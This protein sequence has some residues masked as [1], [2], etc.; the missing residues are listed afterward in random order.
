MA[1]SAN[2]LVELE[3]RIF[4]VRG[5][6]VM[7][8]AD[9]AQLYG[10]ETKALL[11]AMRRNRDRLPQDFVFH[12]T[13]QEVEV[14]RSQIVSSKPADG[15]GGRRYTC[16]AFTEQGVAMLSSVLRSTTAVQVN[17]AIMRAFVRLRRASLISA[18][19]MKLIEDLSERVNSHD[20]AIGDLVEAIRQLA[21]SPAKE[22]SRP[23]G[24]TVDLDA[25]LR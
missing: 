15:R 4:T 14:L 13:N 20:Q 9:L 6:S 18:E 7:L 8:D 1:K 12:L 21:E 19:L 17:I 23:I 22:R 16:Y 10:V 5:Q 3:A 24:F 11:Q 2:N 25:D